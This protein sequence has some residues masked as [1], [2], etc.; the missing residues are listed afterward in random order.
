M[1]WRVGIVCKWFSASNSDCLVSK[2]ETENNPLWHVSPPLWLEREQAAWQMLLLIRWAWFFGMS[3][4]SLTFVKWVGFAWRHPWLFPGVHRCSLFADGFP[5]GSGNPEF[6]CVF[7]PHLLLS[8]RMVHNNRFRS[9]ERPP[10]KKSSK[11]VATNHNQVEI[12]CHGFS[13]IGNRQIVMESKW[14]FNQ[15]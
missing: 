9:W 6:R 2:D 1:N 8:C 13:F 7:L 5:K 15:S 12:D 3:R 4:F 14:K 11:P 10:D